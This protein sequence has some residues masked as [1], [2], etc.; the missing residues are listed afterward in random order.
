MMPKLDIA[1]LIDPHH[2]RRMERQPAQW[3]T[4]ASVAEVAGLARGG[5]ADQAQQALV[6]FGIVQLAAA[7]ADQEDL[8]VFGRASA[9]DGPRHDAIASRRQAVPSTLARPLFIGA[10]RA[11]QVAGGRGVDRSALSAL[12]GDAGQ[13]RL[14][15]AFCAGR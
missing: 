2:L 7:A 9:Q 6:G 5:A 1:L 11:R 3:A 10:Q 12:I 13:E 8:A 4:L 15:S 14:M